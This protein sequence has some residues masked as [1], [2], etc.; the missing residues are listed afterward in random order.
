MRSARPVRDTGAAFGPGAGFCPRTATS[1]GAPRD[2][3]SAL[4]YSSAG[5]HP[6]A[7]KEE[8]E[9]RRGPARVGS[10]GV[11]DSSTGT[12]VSERLPDGTAEV[13]LPSPTDR[14]EALPSYTAGLRQGAKR[15]A[16][17]GKA[18]FAN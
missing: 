5:D 11:G 6:P 14:T 3:A 4:Q 10:P 17:S 16:G 13:H 7:A 9:R 15:H 2:A 12:A 1:R 18:R 8:E